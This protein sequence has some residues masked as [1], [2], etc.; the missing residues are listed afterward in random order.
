MGNIQF[1]KD[2]QNNKENKKVNVVYYPKDIKDKENK[3][4]NLQKNRL[5]FGY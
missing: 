5:T 4:K 1:K 3:N 2:K